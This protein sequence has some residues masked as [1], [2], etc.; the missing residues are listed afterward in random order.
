MVRDH[1]PGLD[2]GALAHAFDRFWQ[3]DAARTGSGVGLGLSIVSA[4]ASEHGGRA[5][6]ENMPDGGACFTLALPTE[7]SQDTAT[8]KEAV[9]PG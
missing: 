4:I 5:T 8:S 1:G 7:T 9:S 3:A 6:V 2:A